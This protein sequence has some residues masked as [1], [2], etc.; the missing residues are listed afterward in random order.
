MK[1]A[2]AGVIICFLF[3]A[4]QTLGACPEP[5]R[6]FTH[7]LLTGDVTRCYKLTSAK[8]TWSQAQRDC[9]RQGAELA[10]I[11]DET[12]NEFILKSFANRARSTQLLIGGVKTSD[13]NFI[14]SDGSNTYYRNFPAWGFS[15]AG[16]ENCLSMILKAGKAK[17][18]TWNDVPCDTQTWAS[19]CS[20][21]DN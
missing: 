11:G 17:V 16:N 4:E 5:W 2:Q 8:L 15:D 21:P 1:I 9:R 14:W 7:T 13:I 6:S 19:V 18:G 3:F 12:V 10:S 20:M